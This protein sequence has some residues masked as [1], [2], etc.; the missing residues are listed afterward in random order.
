MATNEKPQ[1]I[2]TETRPDEVNDLAKHV[3]VD[4]I[5]KDEAMKV[6]ANYTG[7]QAWTEEEEKRLRRKIDRRLLPIMCIT[8]GECS[9]LLPTSLNP[10]KSF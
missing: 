2:Q 3:V 7:D 9:L 10:M 5:H 6:L 8:Y 1:D 4:T